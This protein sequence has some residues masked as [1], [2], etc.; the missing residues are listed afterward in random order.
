MAA[1][2]SVSPWFTRFGAN[3]PA[4]LLQLASRRNGDKSITAWCWQALYLLQ[5][6]LTDSQRQQ[7]LD[8]GAVTE[9]GMPMFVW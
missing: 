4:K 9:V 5:P 8:G 3:L 2:V 6:E 1:A 7:I